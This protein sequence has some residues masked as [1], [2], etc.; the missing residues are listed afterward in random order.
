MVGKSS[1]LS[2]ANPVAFAD[3]SPLDF[4]LFKVFIDGEV[5][6]LRKSKVDLEVIEDILELDF[7]FQAYLSPVFHKTIVTDTTLSR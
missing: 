2:S 7:I 3:P 5:D 6:G 1:S 4:G